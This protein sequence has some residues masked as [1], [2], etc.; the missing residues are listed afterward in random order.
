MKMAPTG[1][2][3]LKIEIK[4]IEKQK[5]RMVTFSKRR[6]GLFK[7]A[8]EYAN[9]TGSQIA[10]LV[11]SPAGNPYVHGSPSFDAV[12]DKFLSVNGGASSSSQV[13]AH[14]NEADVCRTPTPFHLVLQNHHNEADVCRGFLMALEDKIKRCRSAEDLSAVKA[15]LEE[16]RV[17]VLERL[18]HI[19]EDEFVTSLLNC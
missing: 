5:A 7:K 17:K 1:K 12:I 6:Q 19:E 10:V 4:K 8:Q 16:V 3:K 14:H 2:G 18:K 9:I 11:F 13:G 15:E